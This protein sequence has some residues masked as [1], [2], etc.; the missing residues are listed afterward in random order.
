MSVRLKHDRTRNIDTVIDSIRDRI[1]NTVPGVSVEFSQVLQD[2]I[3]DLSGVPEPIE[4]KVF[5]PNQKTIEATARQA[6]NRMRS[7]HGVVDVFD[8]IVE[9]IPEQAVVVDNTSAAHY[10]LSADDIRGA[11]ESAIKGPSR[12]TSVGRSVGRRAGALSRH[13]PRGSR[14]LVGGDSQIEPG[15]ARA[16]G[17][18]VTKINYLGATNEID[19]ERQR[20]VVHVTAR[21]EA[22]DLGTAVG[23]VK[24]SLA[25]MPLPA[26]VSLEYGGSVRAAATGISRVALVLVA[27]IIYDVFGPGLGVRADCA[28]DRMPRCRDFMSGRQLRRAR[29]D[30]HDAQHF[31]VHGNHHGRRHH[32]EERHPAARSC[33]A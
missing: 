31:V 15:G 22:I 33:R 6:A 19:R 4:V 25:R 28:R 27:G 10:G 18:S 3:G 14:D 12:P 2:L 26:G 23:E 9:S 1:L 16:A 29:R 11:L 13:V 24:Q 21:L 20:P 8:G 30:R 32:C 17:S 5:G 7:I